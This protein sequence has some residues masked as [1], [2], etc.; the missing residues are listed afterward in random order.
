MFF[1]KGQIR[2]TKLER[3]QKYNKETYK[4]YMVRVRGDSALEG[5]IRE[6]LA[7]GETSVNFLVNQLLCEYFDVPLHHKWYE[8]R[9]ITQLI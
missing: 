9:K 3:N 8:Q 2:L 1:C 4:T 7:S 6:Y 5:C